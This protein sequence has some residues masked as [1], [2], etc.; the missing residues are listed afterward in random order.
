MYDPYGMQRWEILSSCILY[1]DI[2]SLHAYIAQNRVSFYYGSLHLGSGGALWKIFKKWGVILWGQ[3]LQTWLVAYHSQQL[4][5]N[6]QGNKNNHNQKHAKSQSHNNSVW[7][8][9]FGL[10]S[11]DNYCWVDC[12]H[13]HIISYEVVKNS[14]RKTFNSLQGIHN[15][16]ILYW[17]QTTFE[18]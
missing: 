2:I 17:F 14:S 11:L 16:A 10:I 4:L 18:H 8:L 13:F 9:T 12:P 3:T 6:H 15:V 5:K 7:F 1:R